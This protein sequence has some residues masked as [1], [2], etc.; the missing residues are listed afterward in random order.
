MSMATS[1]HSYS[2]WALQLFREIGNSDVQGDKKKCSTMKER[3]YPCGF[4][5]L[6]VGNTR[7]AYMGLIWALEVVPT[8]IFFFTDCL[9]IFTNQ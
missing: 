2:R 3:S 8:V 7:G 9:E 5:Y 1:C 6:P 4:F